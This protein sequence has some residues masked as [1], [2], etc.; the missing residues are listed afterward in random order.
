MNWREARFITTKTKVEELPL[1]HHSV[2]VALIGRSNAGKSSFLNA[3]TSN[4]SLA[5]TSQTPGKTRHLNLF[6]VGPHLSITDLP[7]Y[8]YA[9]R[10]KEEQS[11]WSLFISTYLR[12]RPPLRLLLLIMD[13]RRSIQEEEKLIFQIGEALQLPLILVLNKCDQLNQSELHR[14]KSAFTQEKEVGL[15]TEALFVSCR[16]GRGIEEARKCIEQR[17]LHAVS[18]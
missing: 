1:R 7:G 4:T 11:D 17:M 14:L 13:A 6:Y 8:G 2:E 9:K 16:T 15:V 10:S 12:E 5:K 18:S 3:L